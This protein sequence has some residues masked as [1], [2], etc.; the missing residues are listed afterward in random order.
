[1]PDSPEAYEAWK[2]LNDE[3]T[4]AFA[5]ARA[6]RALCTEAF[7]A[8]RDGVGTG[9]TEHQLEDAASREKRADSLKGQI[10]DL[11]KATFG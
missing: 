10:D 2:Q 5:N 3:W 1:M 7:V 8:C 9:P 4:L 6:A 11:I